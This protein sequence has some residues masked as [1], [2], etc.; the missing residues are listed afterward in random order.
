VIPLRAWPEIRPQDGVLVKQCYMLS[1]TRTPSTYTLI[2]QEDCRARAT[3][4]EQFP[5]MTVK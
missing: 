5:R 3:H 1:V 4:A 2:S